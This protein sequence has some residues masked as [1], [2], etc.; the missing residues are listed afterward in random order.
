MM[1]AM[2]P[3]AIRSRRGRHRSTTLHNESDD[4]E[5]HHRLDDLRCAFQ[6]TWH[7]RIRVIESGAL[8]TGR[9]VSVSV[10]HDIH[11]YPGEY[12]WTP[13]SLV[14]EN[15]TQRFRPGALVPCANEASSRHIICDRVA[16]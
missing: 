12:D 15:F 6:S 2:D 1:F 8:R 4:A 11:T 13:L 10:R 5:W 3:K 9:K 14:T 7:S 16:K